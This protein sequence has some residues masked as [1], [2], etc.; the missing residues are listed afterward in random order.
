MLKTIREKDWVYSYSK[1]IWQVY[2]VLTNFYDLDGNKGKKT[3]IFSKRIVNEKWEK[4]FSNEVCDISFVKKLSL[5]D[6]N[7]LKK[8]IKENPKVYPSFIEYSGKPIDFILNLN[9]DLSKNKLSIEEFK[10]ILNKLFE[11]I[12]ENGKTFQEIKKIINESK[13]NELQSN[14]LVT[15]ILQFVCKN[16][17]VRNSQ[18]IFRKFNIL[19]F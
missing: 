7:R 13:L 5:L 19:N 16:H 8:F 18:L 15:N 1:G 17:E 12:N 11:N 3:L 9:F 10:K 2:R 6:Y 4:S 14:R